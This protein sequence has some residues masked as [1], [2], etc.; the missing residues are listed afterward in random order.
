MQSHYSY[1]LVKLLKGLPLHI[2]SRIIDAITRTNREIFVHSTMKNYAFENHALPM[3]DG[4]WISSPSTVAKM[5]AYLLAYDISDAMLQ[6]PDNVL[7]IGLGSGY[8]A[9]VLS[10]LFRRVFGI[11]RIE[12]LLFEA[13]RRIASLQIQNI[14]TMYADGM[15]GWVEHAPYDRILLSACANEIPNILIEQLNT[16]AILV[17]PL[18]RDGRQVIVRFIK[19]NGMLVKQE[20]LEHCQFVPIQEGIAKGNNII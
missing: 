20:V 6:K 17:A 5:S 16:N 8:Q 11:E 13:R 19:K 14:T 2:D 1:H 9:V 3:N 4:Q 15:K 7:E 18:Y 10:H 12:S